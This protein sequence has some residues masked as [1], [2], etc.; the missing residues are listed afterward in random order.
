MSSSSIGENYKKNFELFLEKNCR[1]N[2]N[3]ENTVK[4]NEN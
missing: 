3:D 2:T 4:N 1:E